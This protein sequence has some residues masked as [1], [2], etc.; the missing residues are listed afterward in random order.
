MK[1]SAGI[2]CACVLIG[3][4]SAN[5]QTAFPWTGPYV[6]VDF[7]WMTTRGN[8]VHVGDVVEESSTS[9]GPVTNF[10]S[11][12]TATFTP[13]IPKM[14][15]DPTLI[16]EGGY[17][18][19][20]W[21]F[22][23]RG[24]WSKTDGSET[25]SVRSSTFTAPNFQESSVNMF[26][27]SFSP[28][29][30]NREISGRGPV[31]YNATNELKH[32][33]IDGYAERLWVSGAMGV[34]T[35]RFGIGY[36]SIENTRDESVSMTGQFIA[37]PNTFNDDFSLGVI[38][39]SEANLIGPTF[40]IAGEMLLGQVELDWLVSPAALMGTA[41]STLAMTGADISRTRSTATGSTTALT[42]DTFSANR[43][44]ERRTLVPTLD[45]QLKAGFP[46]LPQ[47]TVGG[48]IFSSMLFDMP[49][50]PTIDFQNGQLIEQN[51]TVTYLGYSVFAKYKF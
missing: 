36:A 17:R 22:G 51:R 4:S 5:A 46:V 42:T 19:T 8:D 2:V 3:A 18:G 33:R 34:V 21:G 1:V 47:L 23:G 41:D 45:L 48:G 40:G 29:T 7:V 13:I 25:A 32:L 20:A 27:D 11:S 37:G 35:M 6:S 26:Y 28:F 24:W 39:G 16:I 50:A 38:G 14:G 43:T 12:D 30:D 31:T 10:A 15:T 49:V 9:S 44:A